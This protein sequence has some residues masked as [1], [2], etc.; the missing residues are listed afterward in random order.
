MSNQKRVVLIGGGHAQL[1]VIKAF[2]A[3]ARPAN[4]N[5]T[6]IDKLDKA[7]YSGMVPGCV[8]QY[9]SKDETQIDLSGLSSW[10][11]V[12]FCRGTVVDLHPDSYLFFLQD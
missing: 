7:T 11:G 10:A 6:L 2:N 12:N 1:Q 3:A 9:Y 5:I 8:A 4:W